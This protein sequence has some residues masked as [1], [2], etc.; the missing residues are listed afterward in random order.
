MLTTANALSGDDRLPSGQG[1]LQI[2]TTSLPDG[3]LNQYY[4]QTLTCSGGSSPCSWQVVNSALPSGVAFDSTAGAVL[5]MPTSVETGAVTVSA[6]DPAWPANT[7]T[8][9][10]SLTIAPPPL[11]SARFRSLPGTGRRRVSA[12][13]IGHRR[14]GVGDL[15]D[16]VGLAAGRFDARSIL[17]RHRGRAAVW[18]TTTAVVQVQDS[19]RIDRT[20]AKPV[21]ITVVPT[22]IAITTTTLPSGNVGGMFTAVL[23]AAGGTGAF[24]WSLDSGA[25]PGGVTLSQNGSLAGSLTSMGTFT[26]GVKATDAGWPAN[27]ATQTLTLSVTAS[28]VVLYAAEAAVVTGTWSRVADATAAA[29]AR[30]WNPDRG[31]AKVASALAA[32]VNYFEMT[33]NAQAGVAYHL[34]MRGKAD[35]NSWANDS[36]YV[37]FSG[38]VDAARRRVVSHRHD[39]GHVGQHRERHQRRASPAGAGP[40]IPMAR[41]LPRSTS[42]P[43]V[44]RP[45]AC[46][47]VKTDCRSTRSC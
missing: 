22:P 18:G 13:A 41:W 26:F 9:T 40:T 2:T 45:F 10:L 39:G 1:A 7:A 28:E 12:D 4:A 25:L 44:R 38:A 23:G 19:W 3:L 47:C 30:L 34:W 42:R 27:A 11:R 20:D 24:A 8:A 29:G 32:P 46:R 35:K 17:R 33:F 14:P 36:V 16:R 37:Q 5:G 15:V 6:Y 43:P 21:T 31:A